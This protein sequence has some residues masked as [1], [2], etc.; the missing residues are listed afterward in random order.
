MHWILILWLSGGYGSHP[1]HISF[2]NEQA[3]KDAFKAMVANNNSNGGRLYGVC[4]YDGSIT[5]PPAAGK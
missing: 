4:V 5:N 3:C 2:A 1:D